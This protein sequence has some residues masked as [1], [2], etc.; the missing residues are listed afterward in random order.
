M[1][2]IRSVGTTDRGGENSVRTAL[3]GG[4]GNVLL[5]DDG[6]GPFVL[7]QLESRFEFSDEI[8]L[9]DLGTPALDL[10]HQ[11]VGLRSLILIDSVAS[12]DPPGTVLLYRKDDILRIAPAERL[13][14]HSPALSECLMTAEM[15]G[16]SP[17]H[18]L[19]V[20]IVGESYEPGAPLSES[21]K[22]AIDRAIV[23]ILNELQTLGYSFRVKTAPDAPNVWWTNDVRENSAPCL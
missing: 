5:G 10:T 8:E 12:D 7:R 14:P 13:D 18:V 2:H 22:S 11:I 17:Q 1:S 21:V 20:G 3:I 15:L 23:E 9:I 4:V 16:S 19:L 6:V